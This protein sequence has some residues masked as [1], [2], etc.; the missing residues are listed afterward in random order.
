[1]APSM[2]FKSK[3]TQVEAFRWFGD[4]RQDE[5]PKWIVDG[6]KNGSVTFQEI[7]G[8]TRM[9]IHILPCYGWYNWAQPGDWVIRDE[10]GVHKTMENET[11]ILLYDSLPNSA[12]GGKPPKA[13][14]A[15]VAGSTASPCSMPSENP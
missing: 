8:Q 11:F 10:D 15:P 9:R 7:A 6:I 12:M 14:A 4:S 1:M 3:P 2:I 13:E 5:D